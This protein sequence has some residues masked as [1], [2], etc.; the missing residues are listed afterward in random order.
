M[1]RL[2]H[3]RRLAVTVAAL[4]TLAVGACTGDPAGDPS[5]ATGEVDPNA[6]LR[7]T[8]SSQTPPASSVVAPLPSTPSI[9]R[10]LPE[11]SMQS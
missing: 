1:S 7:V 8:A 6:V 9:V 2:A 5:T 4:A 10:S 3:R 11:K